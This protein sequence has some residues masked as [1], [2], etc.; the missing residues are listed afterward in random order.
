MHGFRAHLRQ[1]E[2]K[3]VTLDSLWGHREYLDAIMVM[4]CGQIL[5]YFD[6]YC[7]ISH[8][9]HTMSHNAFCI[10]LVMYRAQGG[11][12]AMRY[13]QVD[14]NISRVVPT[15]AEGWGRTI[16]EKSATSI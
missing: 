8:I 12:D 2:L 15:E 16:I 6:L 1:S 7:R 11:P 4:R 13:E 5:L 9:W 3:K 10:N 14:C